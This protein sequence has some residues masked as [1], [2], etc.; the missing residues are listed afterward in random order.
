MS[1]PLCN[2][3]SSGSHVDLE[4]IS[5]FSN[6]EHLTLFAG[7]SVSLEGKRRDL[8]SLNLVEK[9][10]EQKCTVVKQTVISINK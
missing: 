8:P 5:I 6:E 1:S 2:R 3:L 4:K 10:F 7:N 9:L